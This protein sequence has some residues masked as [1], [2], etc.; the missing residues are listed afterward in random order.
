MLLHQHYVPHTP[1][2]RCG[3]DGRRSGEGIGWFF[4]KLFP[5]FFKRAARI[6]TKPLVKT[7]VRSAKT[8]GKK[9]IKSASK[10]GLKKLAKEVAKEGASEIARL[11]TEKLLEGI[12]TISNK[13]K[14]K[15]VPA[16]KIDTA[17]AAIRKGLKNAG[18][19]LSKSA[20]EKIES[21]IDKLIPTT[22]GVAKKRRRKAVNKPPSSSKFKRARKSLINIVDEA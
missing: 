20:A 4:R 3:W 11:G 19:S 16:Q 9:A 8:I 22:S 12:D 15:G 5:F 2:V 6:V 18:N 10:H 7:V 21:G 17:A 14:Q 1:N 13:A